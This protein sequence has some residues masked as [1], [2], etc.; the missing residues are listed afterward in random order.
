MKKNLVVITGASSGIGDAIA[1]K[2]ASEGYP[3]LLLSRSGKGI[4]GEKIICAAVD[5]TDYAAL[6]AAVREAENRFGP[7]GILINNAGISKRGPFDKQPPEE[8]KQIIDINIT[9]VLNGIHSVFESMI[10][11]KEGTIINLGSTSGKRVRADNT[12]YSASKHA[13]HAISESLRYRASENNVRVMTI[14]PGPT[15][16]PIWNKLGLPPEEVVS[17]KEKMH[18]MQTDEL[19]NVIYYCANLPQ[20]IC[21]KEL[22]VAPTGIP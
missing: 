10:E 3:L 13:V 19:A 4:Q 8:Y 11:R 14:A 22:I 9:G 6:S 18:L 20:H 5:V 1:E 17:Y 7:T 16:S 12:A 2:F 21:V 15:E